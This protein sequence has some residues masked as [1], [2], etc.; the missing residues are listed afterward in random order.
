MQSMT[1]ELSVVI[2]IHNEAESLEELHRELTATLGAWGRL[3]EIIVVDDGSTDESYEILARL[4]AR[5][6]PDLVGH[7]RPPSR[8]RLFAQGVSRRHREAAAAV[9]RDALVPSRDCQRTGRDDFRDARPS[10][11]EAARAVQLRHRANDPRDSRFIDG[12]VSS[13]LLDASITDLRPDWR[14]DGTCRR[15]DPGL[16]GR[17]PGD[18]HARP[19]ARSVDW[20]PSGAAVRHPAR[21]HGR[22]TGDAR[23]A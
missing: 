6:P 16:A 23:V 10:S 4:Q 22:A 5:E 11:R 19:D 17:H 18:G 13:E 12:Q 20:Q 1:P 15:D 2:P 3:Y 7:R 9:W 14:H 8:L 21:V